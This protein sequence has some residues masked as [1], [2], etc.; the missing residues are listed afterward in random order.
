MLRIIQIIAISCL[1]VKYIKDIIRTRKQKQ[2][3]YYDQKEAVTL[4]GLSEKVNFTLRGKSAYFFDLF[5]FYVAIF[6]LVLCLL[7]VLY[8]IF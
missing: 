6:I 4:K 8:S 1:F 7:Y 2:F 3:Y 5:S